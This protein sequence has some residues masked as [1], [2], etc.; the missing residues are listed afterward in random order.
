MIKIILI[1][2]TNERDNTNFI[3]VLVAY[4]KVIQYDHFLFS[5]A[6]PDLVDTKA[7]EPKR[8][9]RFAWYYMTTTVTSTS[10]A[11]ATETTYTSKYPVAR[12]AS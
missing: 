2:I 5:G 11:T 7:A 8:E 3:H 1:R 12:S 4:R 6:L 10:V 9:G